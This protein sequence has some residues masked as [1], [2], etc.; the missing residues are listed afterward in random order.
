[1][2]A[3]LESLESRMLLSGLVTGGTF[4]LVGT[5]PDA[6]AQPTSTGKVLAALEAFNGKIYAGFGDYNANT[7]PIGIRAFDPATDTFGSRLL[8]SAT[9]AVY[10]FRLIG[11]QL[12]APDIDPKAGESTGG[13]AIGTANG[14]TEIWQ[15]KNPVTVEHMYDVA[16]YGGSLWMAGAQTNNNAVIWRSTDNGASWSISLSVP[17]PAGSGYTYVRSYGLGVY[18]GKLYTAVDGEASKSHIFDGTSWSD[19]PDLTPGGGFLSN[20]SSFDGYMVYQTFE[21]GL[22]ASKMYKFDGTIAVPVLDPATYD[23]FF[24]YKIVGSRMYGLVA[25]YE[26]LPGHAGPTLQGVQVRWTDDLVNWQTLA[27]APITARSLAILNNQQLFVG[28]TNAELY[29]YVAPEALAA[30]CLVTGSG[31]G[32][33][34]E[35][36]V[37]A[38]GSNSLA[39]NLLVYDSGFLGGVRVASGDLTGDGIPDIIAGTGSGAAHVKVFDGA[40]G[41]L[42]PGPLGSFLVYP[43]PGNTPQDPNSDYYRLAFQG[44]IFVASGDVDGDGRDDLITAADAG[45]GPHVKVYSGATGA[46]LR[47]FWAFDPGFQ[48]GVRIATGDLDGDGKADIICGSGV[49]AAHVRI[50]S[51]ATGSLLP[52]ALGSFLIYPGH[53]GDPADPTSDY[54]RLAFQGGIFVASGDVDDDGRDDLITGADAGGGPHVKVYSGLSGATLVPLASFWAYDQSFAGGVRVSAGDVNGDGRADII[55]GTGIGAAQARAFNLTDFA[56]PAMLDDLTAYDGATGGVYV[57]VA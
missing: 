5:H 14:S 48:G 17:P 31:A 12:Y 30:G 20:A 54:Y 41:Q 10:Q 25:D 57:A 42:I 52:G 53:S 51:G 33:A 21:A 28:A 50:Y 32:T 9:E 1:M 39:Q 27:T 16:S 15:H 8:N 13:Y 44:G 11:G 18:N 26:L 49:G 35:V 46:M 40:T 23:T 38:P 7:G 56:H 37:Y 43:G 47:S 19:G 34:P 55:T 45:A 6:S 2:N 3:F 29:Q 22:G 24:D 4:E 36:H